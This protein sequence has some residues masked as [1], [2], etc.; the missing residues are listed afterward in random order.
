MAHEKQR[1]VSCCVSCLCKL[2][3]DSDEKEMDRDMEIG[4][5]AHLESEIGRPITG[6][7]AGPNLKLKGELERGTKLA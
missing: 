1:L 4:T 6:P 5:H 3:G 2:Y 7:T